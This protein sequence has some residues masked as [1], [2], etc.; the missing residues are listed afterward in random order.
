MG[1]NPPSRPQSRASGN[2]GC[3][4][5][6]SS[7]DLPWIFPGSSLDLPWIFPGRRNSELLPLQRQ[8]AA[9]DLKSNKVLTPAAP[10][11]P[12]TIFL[13]DRTNFF[14]NQNLG[15]REASSYPWLHGFF[16]FLVAERTSSAYKDR[17]T[18][19]A[20]IRKIPAAVIKSTI[21][22]IHISTR[23]CIDS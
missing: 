1:R 8:V 22:V 9:A 10:H 4:K 3:R 20:E 2:S 16:R 21:H 23:L 13:S 12:A 7:L 19:P 6:C 14:P 18:F 5:P 11:V 17:S 15:R